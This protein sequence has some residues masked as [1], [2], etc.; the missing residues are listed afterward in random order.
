MRDPEGVGHWCVAR[1]GRCG[2]LFG[3]A[4]ICGVYVVGVDGGSCGIGKCCYAYDVTSTS[5]NYNSQYYVAET[6]I[7]Q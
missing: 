6:N 5:S 1:I 3:A 7:I 2:I 4:G